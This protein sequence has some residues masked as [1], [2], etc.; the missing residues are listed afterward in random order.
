MGIFS[1]SSC[2]W[3]LYRTRWGL[4]LRA[5]GEHPRAADTVGVSVLRGRWVAVLISGVMAG[6]RART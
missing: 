6:S 2:T 3:A 5:L 1:R 4:R